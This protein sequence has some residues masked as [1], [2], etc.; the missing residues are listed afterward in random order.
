MKIIDRQQK[1]VFK[2][3][4]I[5]VVVGRRGLGWGW[6]GRGWCGGGGGFFLFIDI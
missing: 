2:W 4:D 6:V 5:V 3:V 1:G